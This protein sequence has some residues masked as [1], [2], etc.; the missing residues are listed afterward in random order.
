MVTDSPSLPGTASFFMLCD[1]N[2]HLYLAVVDMPWAVTDV[3]SMGDAAP[4]PEHCPLRQF[5][6]GNSII[7][8]GSDTV[9][10]TVHLLRVWVSF[11]A[12]CCSGSLLSGLR[13]IRNSQPHVVVVCG[14]R[15][16]P[17]NRLS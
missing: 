6:H 10:A 5:C 3:R 14:A 9:L 1:E 7:P 4:S 12:T 17:R 2:T 15:L 11:F 16:F 13:L 8:T